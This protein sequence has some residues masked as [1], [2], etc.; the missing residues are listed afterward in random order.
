LGSRFPPCDDRYARK[1]LF[2]GKSPMKLRADTQFVRFSVHDHAR[3]FTLNNIETKEKELK[4]L[5]KGLT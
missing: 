4:M 5:T 1:G 3:L 2:W